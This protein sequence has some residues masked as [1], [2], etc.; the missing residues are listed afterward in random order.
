MSKRLLILAAGAALLTSA[1]GTLPQGEVNFGS[2]T[3]FVTS[4]MDTLDNVGLGASAA[5]NGDGTAFV[6]YFGFPAVLPKGQVAPT[7][8]I[9]S[10][11]LPAVQLSSMDAKGIVTHGAVQ[12]SHPDQTPTGIG[13]P[14]GPDMP[15]DAGSNLDITEQNVNGTAVA[16]GSDGSIHVVWAGPTGIMYAKTTVGGTSTVQEVYNFGVT[17]NQAGPIGRPGIALDADGNPWIAFGVNGSA[18]ISIK[19]ATP[20]GNG[21]SL[22]DAATAGTCNGCPQ[23]LPTG[24]AFVGKT[25]VVVFGDP[26]ANAVMAATLTG[27]QWTTSAVEPAASG[28][29][30]SLIAAGDKA[31]AS[32]YT[33]AGAVHEATFDG[34]VWKPG[35]VAPSADPKTTS[36]VQA[37][38]TGVAVDDQGTIYVTWEDDGVHLSSGDGSTFQPV[39]TQGALAGI[40]PTLAAGTGVVY[41]AWYDPTQQNLNLGALANP[42]EVLLANPSPAPTISIAPE[43]NASCGADGKISLDIV[44][45]GIAFDTNCLVAPAN[46]PFTIN[47]D[48]QD[49]G[50]QHNVAGF[51]DSSA[52]TV[53]FRGDIITGIAK[54]TY[55]VDALK[56]GS[57]YFHCD[58][59]PTT[60]T[61]TLAVVAPKGSK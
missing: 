47:F 50:V 12:Q 49:A 34:I 15:K 58:V 56:P 5:V 36:G 61:G 29:G 10:P 55:K 60:M 39:D 22:T 33:G 40:G 42:T 3:R 26:K 37:P 6:S 20:K 35:E 59:H 54:T 1:C 51:T 25:P 27:T 57:Y 16:L 17:L 2:S 14:F 32:Y 41:L 18:G 53:L 43:A 30:L 23:P 13:V 19:V 38:T 44:A 24:I 31:Y 7:R 4:V 45:K 28:A 8:P 46:E 48:N 9:G 21:W 11:F 52:T